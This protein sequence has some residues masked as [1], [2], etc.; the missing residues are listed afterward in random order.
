MSGFD[1]FKLTAPLLRGLERAGFVTPTPMQQQ[2]IPAAQ[3]GADLL[4]SAATGS[5]KTAAFLL[6]LMQRLLAHPAPRSATR[7]LILV[8]TRELAQQIERHF[9]LL[10]SY[11]R[12][13]IG[14][15]TGG[16]PRSHQLPLLR[17]NPDIIVATP[18][19]LLDHLHNSGNALSLRDLEMLVLDE[20]DRMLDLGFADDVLAIVNRCHTPRQTW[21]FSATLHHRRLRELIDPALHQPQVITLDSPRHG[22][23]HPDITHQYILSDSDA[24]KLQQLRW[25]LGE[26]DGQCLVFVN[27][28]IRAESLGQQ[29][30]DNNVRSGVLH[31]ELDQRERN[32]IM[33]LFQRG[34]IATLVATDVA[35]RGLDIPAVRLVVNFDPPRSGDDY[36]HRTG[37]T[38]RAGATGVAISLIAAADWNR[39]DSIARYLALTPEFRA[40]PGL[41]AQFKGGAK[42][43]S[44]PKSNTVAQIKQADKPRVK[45]RWRDRKQIGKRR[46]PSATAVN[47]EAGWQPPPKSPRTE[48]R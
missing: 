10:G 17:K 1:D 8:P 11:T 14:V 37:R 20:A 16:P 15:I 7:A 21:L 3:A 26:A 31:G 43:K 18:G 32:R 47:T 9:L 13:Q 41:K 12:L 35:A 25:L 28:R 42:P 27:Q 5:G 45:D 6:P 48:P 44:K 39:A 34:V 30:R 46:Q 36:L 38:G 19:R 23:G 29:L 2:V 40:L 24:Q 22:G 33:G 4:V